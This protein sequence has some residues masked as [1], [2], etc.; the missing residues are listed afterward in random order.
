M[1]RRPRTSGAR[2]TPDQS[3][4]P[5]TTLLGNVIIAIAILQLALCAACRI[6]QAAWVGV[7]WLEVADKCVGMYHQEAL[8][9]SKI[10]D[11]FAH[12]NPTDATTVA[13]YLLQS[14]TSLGRQTG[15]ITI[16]AL[17]ITAVALLFIGIKILRSGRTIKPPIPATTAK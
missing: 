5:R 16:G 10:K 11:N 2:T 3:M 9:P 4:T 12:I 14:S 13:D 15:N 1:R 6:Q 7:T 8:D 17:A